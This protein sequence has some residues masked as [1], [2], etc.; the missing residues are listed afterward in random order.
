MILTP[1][2]YLQYIVCKKI[3]MLLKLLDIHL[4]VCFVG[5]EEH[6]KLY[7][8]LY[9]EKQ[10]FFI[11]IKNACS[12]ASFSSNVILITPFIIHTLGIEYEE[13]F[14]ELVRS[15]PYCFLVDYRVPERNLDF[16]AFWF[17]SLIISRSKKKQEFQRFIRKNALEGFITQ[18]QLICIYRKT[19]Y[20]GFA[21][22]AL[23]KNNLF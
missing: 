10:V 14:V 21:T 4:E 15:V 3:V 19:I 7:K 16:P 20:A 13:Q 23:I 17:S 6:Y 12:I 22:I 2:R 1:C 5:E 18:H 9:Y 8:N 11:D